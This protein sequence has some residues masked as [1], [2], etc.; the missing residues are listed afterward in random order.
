MQI[1]TCLI[2]SDKWL[3]ITSTSFTFGSETIV[4]LYK[5]KGL[6]KHLMYQMQ[7]EFPDRNLLL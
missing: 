6:Q 1:V 7:S 2:L 3:F 4:I 5:L